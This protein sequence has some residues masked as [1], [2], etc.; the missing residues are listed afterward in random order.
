MAQFDAIGVRIDEFAERV[1]A[2][3]ADTHEIE[4]LALPSRGSYVLVVERTYYAA[5]RPVETADIVFPGDRY[6]L[7]YRVPVE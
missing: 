6:E 1:T 2:R 7:L 3:A 4:R 5:G